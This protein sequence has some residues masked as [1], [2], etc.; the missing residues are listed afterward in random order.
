MT[1]KVKE[2]DRVYLYKDNA[3]ELQIAL[4]TDAMF[5]DVKLITEDGCSEFNDISLCDSCGKHHKV[6]YVCPELGTKG[7]CESCFTDYKKRAKWY[8]E[9]MHYTF[10]QLILLVQ[11]PEALGLKENNYTEEDLALINTYFDAH[12]NHPPK[13]ETFI[14][15]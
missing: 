5:V 14:N 12:S 7:Y 11:H 6:Y 13:I 15:N 3:G 2:T 8:Q 1:R 9:D 10:N 4:K